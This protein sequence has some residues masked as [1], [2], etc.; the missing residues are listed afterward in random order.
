[1]GTLV[2]HGQSFEMTIT[3]LVNIAADTVLEHGDYNYFSNNCHHW[4][5]NFLKK[6]CH[7]QGSKLGVIHT[8]QYLQLA[9]DKSNPLTENTSINESGDSAI[10]YSQM[11][12]KNKKAKNKFYEDFH[13]VILTII[14]FLCVLWQCYCIYSKKQ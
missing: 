12:Q 2:S 5:N 10:N 3:Q 8:R 6:V 13:T 4:G 14:L 7:T 9:F 1:M 11:I